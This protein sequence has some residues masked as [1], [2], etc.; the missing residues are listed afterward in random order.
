MEELLFIIL[1]GLG[2]GVIPYIITLFLIRNKKKN[3]NKKFIELGELVGR[4]YT[5]ITL[6]CGAPQYNMI[7]QDEDGNLLRECEWVDYEFRIKL[8]FDKE[9]ICVHVANQ[10]SGY[11]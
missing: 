3:L 1:F 10:T 8:Y 2:G 4:K 11:C 9:G 5:E 7:R 6:Y